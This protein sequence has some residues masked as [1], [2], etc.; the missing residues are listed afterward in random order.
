MRKISRLGFIVAVV[1]VL[2]AAVPHTQA[3]STN[4]VISDVIVYD[5]DCATGYVDA[6]FQARIKV[7]ADETAVMWGSVTAPGATHPFNQYVG[8]T[9]VGPTVDDSPWFVTMSIG[10]PLAPHT[11]IKVRLYDINSG[12]GAYFTVDCTTGEYA[13]YNQRKNDDEKDEPYTGIFLL[14]E[15]VTSPY[16]GV[17]NAAGA[18]PCG[19]FDVNGWG[20]KYVGMA[21]FPACVAPVEVMCLNGDREWTADNVSSVIYH[22]DYEVDFTSAQD[23]VCAFFSAQ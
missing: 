16:L 10:G 1:C 8:P 4:V 15:D 5:H 9:L 13:I 6:D 20:K 14:N 18:L 17:P 21:D 22:G 11:P 2:V 23:G 3:A 12:G 19:V 7:P